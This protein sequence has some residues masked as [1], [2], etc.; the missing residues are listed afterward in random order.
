MWLEA[1]QLRL[2][3]ELVQKPA[4]DPAVQRADDVGVLPHRVAVRA[5]F[6]PAGESAVGCDVEHGLE[7]QCR[8]DLPKALD[9]IL[10]LLL[11]CKLAADLP[12]CPLDLA[13]AVAPR[14]DRVSQ[15]AS[16]VG[17]TAWP[18]PTRM[19][20]G[21]DQPEIAGT[22][23]SPLSRRRSTRPASCRRWRCRRTPFGCRPSCSASSSVLTAVLP[24][25]R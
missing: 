24:S 9:G 13:Q 16:Q 4:G 23:R 5:V 10:S 19:G 22:P 17:V 1:N 14:Q 12:P 6:E 18:L 15:P 7:A 2:W 3:K 25:T 8:D 11:R 21:G 20:G